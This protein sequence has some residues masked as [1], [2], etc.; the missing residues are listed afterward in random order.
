MKKKKN[1]IFEMYRKYGEHS[2]GVYCK[3]CCNCRK[4]YI[5]NGKVIYKCVAYGSNE[6]PETNWNPHFTACGLINMPFND[7][8]QLPLIN[9]LRNDIKNNNS[10]IVNKR[11]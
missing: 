6:K 4:T 2:K 1:K 3:D 5:K 11:K 9:E 8:E 10:P 7:C